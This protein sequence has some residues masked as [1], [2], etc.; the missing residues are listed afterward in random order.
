MGV[1]SFDYDNDL[2]FDLYWTAWPGDGAPVPNAFYRN[3]G[4]AGFVDVAAETN[5]LDPMGWGISAGIGDID[6]DGWMDFFVTNGFSPASSANVLFR[7]RRDGAFEDVTEVIGGGRFDGRGVAF[8]DYDNDGD[9]DLIVTS[10]DTA[11]TR[12]WRNDSPTVHRW[13]TLKLI[14]TTSNRSAIG[15]RVEVE[16]PIRTTVQEVSGS[17]GRGNQNSLPLEFG[18][19]VADMVLRVTIRWPSGLIQ[20]IENVA[21]DQFLTVVEGV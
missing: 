13:L 6:L 10:G 8:A 18:L 14:G 9:V 11:T 15:A 7:N 19:G 20:V 12:L 3:Q 5:T 21:V 2:D 16:T 1:I 17:A 4:G